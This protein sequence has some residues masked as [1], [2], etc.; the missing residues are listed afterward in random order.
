MNLFMAYRGEVLEIDEETNSILAFLF[1]EVDRPSAYRDADAYLWAAPKS[2]RP[3]NHRRFIVN[4]LRRAKKFDA[5][6]VTVYQDGVRCRVDPRT[7]AMED[8][9][10]VRLTSRDR[11]G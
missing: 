11:R 5:G 2:K 9:A 8:G 4:W 10:K 6:K 1:P 7:Q 3:R